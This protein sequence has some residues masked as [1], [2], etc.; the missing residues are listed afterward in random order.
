MKTRALATLWAMATLGWL[1][2][3]SSASAFPSWMGVYGSY[4]R[5]DGVNPGTFTVLLNQ[6]YSGLKADV[7]IKIGSGSW[8]MYPMTRTGKIDINSIW[9]FTPAT[10][11]PVN[12]PIEYFFYGYD[13]LGG[14]IWD[15]R[16]AQNYS[17]HFSGPKPIQWAGNVSHWPTTGQIKPTND[18]WVNIETWPTGAAVSVEVTF[19]TNNWQTAHALA[20][21]RAGQKGNND[22]WNANLRTFF[23]GSTIEYIMKV[24]DGLGSVL[25]VNNNGQKYN[26]AVNQGVS[27]AWV[28]NQSAWPLN[29]SVRSDSEFWLNVESWPLGAARFATARYSVNGS[30]WFD[31][32]MKRAGQKGNND[33]WH[34]NLGLFPP[35]ATLYYRTEVTDQ[36]GTTLYASPTFLSSRVQ[37][38][39]ADQD[40]DNLPDD[41]ELFWW[42]NRTSDG[43]MNQDLDGT[44]AI[45][46]VNHLEWRLGTEP[47]LS[48]STDS[49][50]LLWKP[51]SPTQRGMVQLSYNP[52]PASSITTVVAAV[53]TMPDQ[54]TWLSG[55]I[56]RNTETGRFETNYV[57]SA[58]ATN[59][60]IHFVSGVTTDNNHGVSWNIPIK[61]LPPSQSPDS[62]ADGISDEW[63]LA[64]GFNPLDD[65]SLNSMDGPDGDADGDGYSNRVEYQAGTNPRKA[66]SHPG[67]MGDLDGDGLT[68]FWE[69][70]LIDFSVTDIINTLADVRPQD[71]F[72][73]D[74]IL[75]GEEFA[76]NSEASDPLSLPSGTRV[77][78]WSAA[79]DHA[80]TIKQAM[81]L[82]APGSFVLLNSG[83]YNL[84]SPLDYQGKPLTVRG[85]GAPETV[86]L[87][88]SM[89]NRL[90][91]ATRG[92]S[93][94]STLENVTLIDGVSESDGGAVLIDNSSP[95]I[96][97]VVIKNAYSLGE[98][99]AVFVRK[100]NPLLER[101]RFIGNESYTRGGGLAV[102]STTGV[103]VKACQFIDNRARGVHA[104][105]GAVHGDKSAMTMVS[106][107]FSANHADRGGDVLSFLMSTVRVD[108]AT[109][110][111]HNEGFR[112]DQA[113]IDVANSII[114]SAGTDVINQGLVQYQ[115][116]LSDVALSGHG[117]IATNP[118]LAS[119][120]YRLLPQSPCINAGHPTNRT[121]DIHGEGPDGR[122]DIG[123]DEF[124]DLDH[125]TLA[126]VWENQSAAKLNLI[127]TADGDDDGLTASQE[128]A[129]GTHP[130][131]VDTDGDGIPDGWEFNNGLNPVD[132]RDVL[133][134][135]DESGIP[136]YY[137]Y[138]RAS[139]PL[140]AMLSDFVVTPNS[141]LT[142]QQAIDQA[143]EFSIIVLTGGVYTGPGNRNIILH[144]KN[145]MIVS[146]GNPSN[147]VIDC[148]GAGRG[149]S[150]GP[151]VD[152]RTLL[153]G[154]TIKNGYAGYQ[155]GEGGGIVVSNASPMI[156]DCMIV[157]NRA[158]IGGGGIHIQHG[159]VYMRNC[160][161]EGNSAEYNE[162]GGLSI[163]WGSLRMENGRI[164]RNTCKNS[165]R[166]LGGG[167]LYAS[168]AEINLF[169][170]VVANNSTDRNGGGIL[171]GYQSRGDVIHCTIV[172]NRPDGLYASGDARIINTILWSN[173]ND[174]VLSPY[175]M[176]RP[177]IFSLIGG[178]F[179]VERSVFAAD[180]KLQPGTYR[181]LASSPAIDAGT[182]VAFPYLD[183]DNEER[184]DHPTISNRASRV[185]LGVD[186]FVDT[187]LDDLADIWEIVHSGSIAEYGTHDDPD[188]DTL[189]MLEEYEIGINP[190]LA[191]TDGDL[192]RDDSEMSLGLN[193]LTP[194]SDGG[195]ILDGR[196][197]SDRD[198]FG[199]QFE[200]DVGTDALNPYSSPAYRHGARNILGD[201]SAK[202]MVL[203]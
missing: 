177:P 175:I 148:E 150:F 41:W 80:L 4:V 1:L 23:G 135:V 200:L 147:C 19:T 38:D 189:S 121:A 91:V 61:S 55:T 58:A 154:V 71:D 87:R 68:D 107:Y 115:Y 199:N 132:D 184:W 69:Y 90:L 118:L 196:R 111:N 56:R 186:E 101:V 22:W 26:A 63:E 59:L 179:D 109:M 89:Q 50:S 151:G 193:P 93:P 191:D 12:T 36:N 98:G 169:N 117:N 16:S 125:D 35:G 11:F 27:V 8:K 31:E 49:I 156:D 180:P 170:T 95:V 92:E 15:N 128:Y 195:T 161:V 6:D 7:G 176:S 30:V 74:G 14:K 33:W 51:S 122:M 160:R 197:D 67:T 145:V 155:L 103:L 165:G 166:D 142:I 140:P 182:P 62:D 39:I 203:P 168:G 141:G 96:R 40:S 172:H 137:K 34:L 18:V 126:D 17:L 153:R 83:V 60:R 190:L 97:D 64:F 37:G 66:R 13:H 136:A 157:S 188:F 108:R 81:E 152:E 129:L 114:W 5:H 164:E 163:R 124:I 139:R 120:S 131:A 112:V 2:V 99:G 48:N 21:N 45:P 192:L 84:S 185:D 73:D 65:G 42:I 106:S 110:V 181:L 174:L 94:A 44:R 102:V 57:V 119:A 32:P 46:L 194:Y 52:V 76:H 78:T 123:C 75:N 146:Q 113:L 178:R 127:A 198:G 77:V 105:G 70:Q 29:G 54:G 104:T 134:D 43:W 25:W 202:W 9:K 72:D 138:Q 116:S 143:P 133:N 173:E 20:M 159:V 28:G 130:D 3:V 10:P 47:T 162:G 158:N 24:T 187:D 171:L 79:E 149:F 100:G 183:L 82:A 201:G 88:A 85:R 86:V 167:G 144:G 53:T